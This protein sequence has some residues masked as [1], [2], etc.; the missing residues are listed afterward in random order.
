MPMKPRFFPRIPP[1]PWVPALL[2]ALMIAPLVLL[3]G[4]GRRTDNSIL[5]RATGHP[6]LLLRN[7]APTSLDRRWLS[8][9]DEVFGGC[10][11]LNADAFV[12]GAAATI[13]SGRSL[14]ILSHDALAAVDTS[15]VREMIPFFERGGVVLMDT[16][17]PEWS[18]VAGLRLVAT[19]EQTH[20]PW[21]R[22]RNFAPVLVKERQGG[23]RGEPDLF[24]IPDPAPLPL[25]HRSWIHRPDTYGVQSRLS[26]FGH[27]E[28]WWHRQEAGGW[29]TESESLPLLLQALEELKPPLHP[30]RRQWAQAVLDALLDPDA[31]PAPWPRV[32]AVPYDPKI[33]VDD[34]ER[35][36]Q[37]RRSIQL[38][39]RWIDD[40]HLEV[41]ITRSRPGGAAQPRPALAVPLQWQG[42]ALVDWKADW[43]GAASRKTVRNAHIFRLIALGD[44]G[45]RLILNY[46]PTG[47]SARWR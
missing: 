19:R 27:S 42:R 3:P 5:R 41:T 10:D 20:L 35:W 40:V 39:P 8:A 1:L 31:F 12:P 11:V 34:P 22:P 9:L 4:C 17:G 45:G 18:Q 32:W 33:R 21:P 24:R 6:I 7:P 30:S 29:I 16:P 28:I 47:A 44:D 14:L 37:L 43:S 13:L 23:T 38:R 15:I 46:R 2:V 36:A 25:P 26:P